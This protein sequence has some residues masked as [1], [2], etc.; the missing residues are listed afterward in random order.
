[1]L[2]Y[3][4]SGVIF[5][6]E[7]HT[8]KLNGKKLHGITGAIQDYF[9]P[10]EFDSIPPSVLKKACDRGTEVHSQIEHFILY[11]IMPTHERAIRFVE[12]G[13]KGLVKSEY[14]V[15][16]KEYWASA[17]DIVQEVEGGVNLLDIKTTSKLHSAKLSWQLS[18]YRYLFELQNP[19][20]Q[21]KKAQAVWLNSKD[22]KLVDV[23][24]IDSKTIEEFLTIAR[25]QLPY[26][27]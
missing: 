6:E 18:I 19:T 9:F 7:Y 3:K 21:V 20:I 11:G 27:I 12:L 5:N 16:D 14:L 13:L 22:A 8:Y 17:I 24:L 25:Y 23:E 26:N 2:K 1:M 4:D 15:T 10:A